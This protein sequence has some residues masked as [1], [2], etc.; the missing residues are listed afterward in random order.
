MKISALYLFI[1]LMI[2]FVSQNASAQTNSLFPTVVGIAKG[3]TPILTSNTLLLPSNGEESLYLICIQGDDN[4]LTTWHSQFA[5]Q[6]TIQ[7]FRRHECGYG[8][9]NLTSIV[10]ST[11]IAWY[12]TYVIYQIFGGQ[13][14]IISVPS[15]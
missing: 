10:I 3:T 5:V 11:I 1:I 7:Y 2:V 15:T 13:S 9:T 12:C 6:T 4:Q 14:L 8:F